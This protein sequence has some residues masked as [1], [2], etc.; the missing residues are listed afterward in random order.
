MK[1]LLKPTFFIRWLYLPSHTLFDYHT[2][3]VIVFKNFVVMT[4]LSSPSQQLHE[5]FVVSDDDQLE[6][7][8]CWGNICQLVKRILNCYKT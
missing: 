1:Y 2:M 8:I 5:I 7:T 3:L 4:N 6:V